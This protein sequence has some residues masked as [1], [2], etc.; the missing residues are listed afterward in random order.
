M[1]FLFRDVSRGIN[2]CW[3]L[4]FFREKNPTT[5]HHLQAKYFVMHGPKVGIAI[6][7]R[8]LY[9]TQSELK[10]GRDRIIDKKAL[11]SQGATPRCRALVQKACTWSSGCRATQWIERTLKLL[12]NI[13]NFFDSFLIFTASIIIIIFCFFWAHQHKAAGLKIKLSKIKWLQQRLIRW[14]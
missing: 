9:V 7:F 13:G 1:S 4:I 12:V 11:L 2:L 5:C 6:V 3:Y 10:H 14:P 8:K